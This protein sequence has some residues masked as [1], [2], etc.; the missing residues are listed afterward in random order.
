MERS[1]DYV[2]ISFHC[3]AWSDF[4]QKREKVMFRDFPYW[5]ATTKAR[6]IRKVDKFFHRNQFGC[7][8]AI[9]IS[10]A[11]IV[12][13]VG[14]FAITDIDFNTQLNGVLQSNGNSGL[15]IETLQAPSSP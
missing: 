12:F 3:Y 14:V 13:I 8:A 7:V 2:Y 1:M 15:T 5:W 10:I 6:T 4:D 11:L 9:V